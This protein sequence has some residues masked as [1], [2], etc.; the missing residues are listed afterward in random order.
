M[1]DVTVHA[2]NHPSQS[3]LRRVA[4]LLLIATALAWSLML[5]VGPTPTAQAQSQ[6]TRYVRL[7][8]L[9]TGTCEREAVLAFPA[10][11]L[12]HYDYNDACDLNYALSVAVDGDELHL[13]STGMFTAYAGALEITKSISLIGGFMPGFVSGQTSDD[14]VPDPATY[15]TNIGAPQSNTQPVIHVRGAIT[16]ADIRTVTLSGLTIYHSAY[17]GPGIAVSLPV[18][19]TGLTDLDVQLIVEDS[20]IQGNGA[21][22]GIAINSGIIAAVGITGTQFTDNRAPHGGAIVLTPGSRLFGSDNSFTGNQATSGSGGAIYVTNGASVN[23]TSATFS[24]NS[25]TGDGGAIYATGTPITLNGSASGNSAGADGGAL[26]IR[27][28]A[29]QPVNLP[30]FALTNNRATGN[31]GGLY[32]DGGSATLGP[33]AITNNRA[34]VH[35]G[36]IFRQNGDLTLSGNQVMTNTAAT[37]AGGGIVVSNSTTVDLSLVTWRNN[38]AGTL[39]G[40]AYLDG[41]AITVRDSPSLR[42][43]RAASGAGLY[44]NAGTALT[45]TNNVDVRQNSATGDGGAIF[46]G[47]PIATI[48]G[49][50]LLTNTASA[51][52]G[53]YLSGTVTSAISANTIQGNQATVGA[54]GGLYLRNNGLVTLGGTLNVRNNTAKTHGGALYAEGSRIEGSGAFDAAHNRADA[55][56]GAVYLAAG[57]NM[58]VTTATLNSNTAALD[59]GA[60]YLNQSNFTALTSTDAYS[61][62][63]T[64][65][66]GGA[67]S[68]T[69]GSAAVLATATLRANRAN[70][71]G[72]IFADA[73]IVSGSALT[74]TQNRATTAAG[75]AIFAHNSLLDWRSSVYLF[76]NQAA[77]DGGGAFLIGSSFEVGGPATVVSNTVG[78]GSGGGL[79]LMSSSVVTLTGTLDLSRNQANVHGGGLYLDTGDL[80]LTA[81]GVVSGNVAATGGGGGWYLANAVDG[82]FGAFSFRNNQAQQSGGGFHAANATLNF[83]APTEIISNTSTADDGGG[84]HLVTGVSTS[85]SLLTLTGNTAAN[86][87]GGLY[88]ADTTV[89]L[90]NDSIIADNGAQ[91]GS[92]GGLYVSAGQLN[93]T[94]IN[95]LRNQA[96][97]DGG[98]LYSTGG[99]TLT[100]ANASQVAHNSALTGSGGGLYAD[101]GTATLT[102]VTVEQNFAQVDGGGLFLTGSGST[103]LLVEAG[104]FV[105]DNEIAT[106]V[107]GGLRTASGTVTLRASTVAGNQ[108][109][110]GGGGLYA[111]GGELIVE[112]SADIAANRTVN[113]SGGGLAI[114]S[115]T[116]TIDN[117]LLR[118]NSADADGGGLYAPGGTVTIT[119]STVISANSVAAGRGGG[120]Y[121]DGVR[122]DAATATFSANQAAQGGGAI[123]AATL[124]ARLADSTL[125]T[126]NGGSGPG[127]A[128]YF[129]GDL[130]ELTGNS[131]TTN[132]TGGNG[133]A[134][135]IEESTA[136]VTDNTVRGNTVRRDITTVTT[137]LEEDVIIE[138][139]GQVVRR[140]GDTITGSDATE[141]TGGALH[142]F[143]TNGTFAR[144]IILANSNLAGEGGGI[145]VS[146]GVISMTNSVVAQNSVALS[147]TYGTGLYVINGNLNLRHVTV[148]DN[149]NTSNEDGVLGIGLYVTKGATETSVLTL[150]NNIIAGH[151]LGMMLLTG[152][153]AAIRGNLWHNNAG[154]W[155]GTGVYSPAAANMIGDPFFVDPDNGN[156][157]IQ[158]ASA[159]FDIGVDAGIPTDI[160]GVPRPRAFGIDAGAYEQQ[161][162]QG[163]HLKV[164]ASPAAVGNGETIEYRAQVVNHSQSALND[165][166]LSF[167]LPAQQSASGI[168][169]PGCSGTSCNLGNL[170]VDQQ[171]EILFNATASGT[172]PDQGFIEMVTNVTVSSPSF[173]ASD[174]QQSITTRLQRCSVAYNGIQYPSLQGAVNAVNDADDL[175]DTIRV[176]GTCGGTLNLSKKVTIQGGWNQSLTE[177]D[178]AR[179]PTTLDAF[180]SDRVLVI[181]GSATPTIENLTLRNG[182]AA[183]KGGGPSGK[184]AG[185][186]VYITESRATLRNIRMV[187]GNSPGYGGGLYVAPLTAPIID[188]SV[189]EN[190]RAGEA[191]GGVYAN[192]S[193]PELNNVTIRNNS[194]RAGGGVYLRKSEAKIN[195]STISN[196]TATGSPSYL[197][198]AG[199]NVRLAIGGGGG[200]NF[201]ESKAGISNST[202]EN[203]TAKAG[204]AIFADNS[205][206]SVTNSLIN[207]NVANG[208]PVIVPIIVL[209]NRAGGG[210]AIY[211]QRSDLVIEN[212]RITNNRSDGP[213]GAIHIFNGSAD[214]KING[215]FIGYNSAGKGAAVYVHLKPD[216][217][218]IFV[219]PIT[220]PDFLLPILLGQPQP[221]PP[222]LVMQ[223]NTI[224]HNSGSS[225]VHLYGESYAEMVANIFAFN[226]GT[227][228][229]A[230]TQ[231]LPYVALIP[232]PIIF[233]VPVPFPVFYVPKADMEYSLFYENGSNTSSSGVGASVT[234][235]NARTGDPA[236]KDDGYHIKRISAA[237]NTG[238]NTGFPTDIDGET[239]PQ[240]SISE[241][242]A[243]EYPGIGVRYVAPTGGDTGANLCR[244]F[245]NPCNS[246]QVAIDSAR[247]GDLIKMAGGT[248]N[249]AAT[250]D[251]QVQLGYITKT[252]TIQGGYYPFTTDND[253]TEGV[254]TDNDWEVPFPDI[255]PTILDAGGKGRIFYIYDPKLLDSE[256]NEIEVKP[257]LSGLVLRNGS[258]DGLRGPQ[259][260]AFDA[261]GAL[262]LDN[263]EVALRDLEITDST[264]DFGGGVYMISST[265]QLDDVVVHNNTAKERGGGFY[266]ETSD[267]VQIRNIT[268]EQNKAP[269]GGGLYLDRSAA[270]LQE[271]LISANGDVNTTTAGGGLYIDAGDARIISN[272]ITA[273]NALNGAGLYVADSSA[274]INDNTITNNKA[275]V[276]TDGNGRGGGCFAGPGSALIQ[277]NTFS[278][279][280]A[281]DGAGCYLE[282]SG[283]L[284]LNNNVTGNI[285]SRAGGGIYLNNSSDAL[286]ENNA[287]ASNNANGTGDSDGGGGLYLE[288][289]NATLR[290]NTVTGNSAQAGGGVYFY[291]FSNALFQEN[292]V[293]QNSANAD[294]GGLYV[295]LSNANLSKNTVTQNSTIVGNGGGIYVKLS[296]AL[297]NE[298]RVE[299]NQA[300]LAG[301]GLYL[302][303]SS[304]Q[305]NDDSVQN[306]EA[307]NGGG[308][309]LF[310]SDA[311]RFNTVTIQAN[312]ASQNGGGLYLRLSDITLEDHAIIANEAGQNGGGAYLDESAVSFNRNTLRDNRAGQQG[313]GIAITRRSNGVFGSNAI[314]DNEA[315]ATGSGVYVAGASPRLI[316]ST[317]AR[318]IGGDGTGVVAVETDGTRSSVTL[319]NTILAAQ[320]LAVRA[321]ANN[322]ITLEATLWDG[323]QQ[324]WLLGAGRIIT[325]SAD[326]N[327]FGQARFQADGIHLQKDSKA[328]GVGIPTEISRDI[329][330][331]GRSQGG[332]PELGADELLADCFAVS[333]SNLNVVFTNVQS[334]INAAQPGDEVRISGTCVGA[335]PRAGVTQLAYIDKQ[336]SVRGGYTPTNWLVA[337]PMT[338][339]TILDAQGLGRVLYIAPG[340]SPTIQDLNLANGDASEQ[341]GGPGGLDAGGVLYVRNA[342][343]TLRNLTISGGQAYYGGGA[344]LQNSTATLRDSTLDGNVGVKGGALFLQNSSATLRGNTIV[345][346]EAEDGGGIFFNASAPT[347]AGNLVAQNAATGAGGGIFMATSGAT[348]R[349]NTVTTNTAQAAGG[350]YVDGAAPQLTRNLVQANTAQNAGGIFLSKSTAAVNGNRVIANSAGIGG[351][352]YVQEG[353][354]GLDNNVI[355]QN[356]GQVQAA[357]LY[358]LSSSPRLRHNTIAANNGGDGEGDGSGILITDLGIAPANLEMVNNIL[359]DHTIAITMTPGNRITIRNSLLFNN[360][361]DWGGGGIVNDLGGHI[362]AAPAFVNPSADDFHLQ[363]SSPARDQGAT[364]AGLSVDFDGQGRPADNGFDIGADEFVFI[365]VKLSVQ[366]IPDPVVAGTPFD[367]AVSLVNIGNVD[368]NATFTATLPSGIIP[369]GRIVRSNSV[370]Q[371]TTWLE[372]ISAQVAPTATGQLR[373]LV[374]VTTDAGL[375]EQAEAIINIAQPDLALQLLADASPNPAPAGG[376]ITY[377]IRLANVGNQPLTPVVVAELPAPV[378]TAAELSWSPGTLEPGG[379]WT[380]L[381]RATVAADA[382]G[383]L[384]ATFR[385]TTTEGPQTEYTLNVPIAKPNLA[386]GVSAAP[387]RAV[388]GST[389]TYTVLVTNTGNVD[390]TGTITYQV[391]VAEGRPLIAPGVDQVFPDVSL[392]AGE[393]HKQQVVVIIEPGYSGALTSRIIV[394]T[395]SGLRTTFD[396]TRQVSLPS[397]GPSITAVQNGPWDDPATWDK[398]RVPNANDIVLVPAE[399][400]VTVSGNTTNPIV[401]T[402]LINRGTIRLLCV[403]G[404]PMRIE[405]SDFIENSGLIRGADAQ[406]IGEPGCAVEIAT[407]TLTNP[408]TIRAGDGADGGI[409][410]PSGDI[411]NGGDG[412]SAS[413]FAQTV[414]NEGTIRGGDGGNVIP[415]ATAG[416]GGSGGDALVVAGPP[417]PG[418]LINRGLIAA[419]NGGNGVSDG[420]NGGHV[421]LLSSAQFTN[422]DGETR[423]GN[424]GEEG[425]ADGAV[426]ISA[427]SIWDNGVVRTNGDDYAYTA[428]AR[429]VVRS[430]RGVTV[431]LPV[432]LLNQ[433]LRA[434]TYFL[435]WT[436]SANWQQ[437]FLPDT[438][439][440]DSLR[441]GILI[442]PL[443][444]PTEAHIGDSS[445]VRLTV[446]SQNDAALVREVTLT[447][448]VSDGGQLFLPYMFNAAIGTA[449]DATTDATTDG[450][451]AA[452]SDK[453]GV[454]S[455]DVPQQRI[456]LPTVSVDDSTAD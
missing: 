108:A 316:H 98:G 14:P 210:G 94:K 246:L 195:N 207:N 150:T 375:A 30:A 157:A 372:T 152:S 15:V 216:T 424:G 148:A 291:S 268:I 376:E 75:G 190:S 436:N 275:L 193:S 339:S 418:L 194:A 52:A 176:S 302:D 119:N 64:G 224:A 181:S 327:F 451:P 232:V 58:T 390:F 206:G 230:E 371:G 297:F 162:T 447:V 107:G 243:D 392:P 43:N 105:R 318:N 359:V 175:P 2:S 170:A 83:T 184:D 253:V 298:N 296:G 124:Y 279:N 410:P 347:V 159:A 173:G 367:L 259:A 422:D 280:Q 80:T 342:N 227:G 191:G 426:S 51:G 445:T 444:I 45:L 113:G 307:R 3:A 78:S 136:I 61:N 395:T 341:G 381:V 202:L 387:Q 18:S 263:V 24:S 57:T 450:T 352:L 301:G 254:Y 409:A 185:G 118:E 217:F 358:I 324:N 11:T 430:G 26:Y 212:N 90:G 29:A 123:Y 208:T 201:D 37:G 50:S 106:G 380:K 53:L 76:D 219:L 165:V 23:L 406:S 337:Y 35:G 16:T 440:V 140:A 22:G 77:T 382:T 319:V 82:T 267:D 344:Y 413:V 41:D 270:L 188:N 31:G 172:P 12:S 226:S 384:Q 399:I 312:Q 28:S 417:D 249:I 336:I 308:I 241:I 256:G 281:I 335:Q 353:N 238:R 91:T 93:F 421:A 60:L 68:A 42:N 131:V 285:A 303:E 432:T 349:S 4:L 66:A 276:A 67:V 433:G 412:G 156:Y 401:L 338:Q 127:G 402:G 200:V 284:L 63:A 313:G 283:A 160:L 33:F 233:V 143:D 204:G 449:S 86:N 293:T 8:G 331:D 225:A 161:Y 182:S 370:A 89:T 456:Y 273:N 205:P 141:G 373:V 130:V 300:T 71:G 264:A 138:Q 388:A 100:L 439:R 379:A 354:P 425:G 180:G 325:G 44:V 234:S 350:I 258:A 10:G 455:P 294:G 101:G 27:G 135:A 333:S 62:T 360:G 9:T 377:Q 310:R 328:A 155:D 84:V 149:A 257:V 414:L 323:N 125:D 74:L 221:D 21:G 99:A 260:N 332:G 442:A 187:G 70:N 346:N 158:R 164:T 38:S 251:G 228:V 415:P 317:I 25:A 203:N 265:I 65:G 129:S 295:K 145:Y 167:V 146:G 92:G 177:L 396:D 32:L 404:V 72:A 454:A 87:G 244:D 431:L 271:N 429:P 111:D 278:G 374:E 423:A 435:L 189:I 452:Q 239:R 446:R 448:L 362:R 6:T 49:N 385:A 137:V 163:V 235:N 96:Q 290:T 393:V 272:T 102:G 416:R 292:T 361:T 168:S 192:N 391:P 314:V 7:G 218:K 40:A 427:A 363:N 117:S 365:A 20:K 320:D 109:Q 196:N 48:S 245:L 17:E 220:I 95:I 178:P 394:Q 36:G 434:D 47:G 79:F 438:F 139:T 411:V 322:T 115:G 348:L 85:F 222:K 329:D 211:A 1:T 120:L 252:L 116:V 443:T 428:L 405:A 289:S 179:F 34:E 13:E 229:V 69:N 397:R 19:P 231:T 437:D 39:G 364:N 132:E 368:Q 304:V 147:T 305:L 383:T 248:Y 262:Y 357:G 88:S 154:D 133:G 240:A 144:N 134:F 255:N 330:G 356:I 128:G 197:E 398:N 171:A 306:N 166:T 199:F 366:T 400:E 309:Y 213:G 104:S 274:Q 282:N 326:L 407:T 46:A 389:L 81:G 73:A 153:R 269:R 114:I 441:R 288:A 351:G 343:P 126:N 299:E 315:G 183:G 378:T 242:G 277:R 287:I 103:T 169:G 198:V 247:D 97:I 386:I 237:Y 408:G 321:T 56:G 122:L 340:V 345:N 453:T 215:N 112:S 142:L 54:G 420:G 174:T 419:G 250:R 121:V 236:F 261:G 311:A 5:L 266:L 59:G 151:D 223:H 214:A 209:A 110:Q 55:H 369:A 286:V 186:I 334:A 355:A 403:V